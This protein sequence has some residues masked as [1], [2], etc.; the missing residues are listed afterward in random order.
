MAD[1]LPNLNSV[2][3]GG[4]K[5][6]FT[7]APTN[8][9]NAG[10]S[11]N[12]L[13]GNDQKGTYHQI[14]DQWF[15]IE[16]GLYN[17][18]EGTKPLY[19]PFSFVDS[20]TIRETL[21]NWSVSGEI[22]FKTDF[23]SFSR[24]AVNSTK[25]SDAP[26]IDRT[27]GRNR[28]HITIYPVDVNTTPNFGADVTINAN[29]NQ[30]FPKKYWEMSMDFIIVDIIDIDTGN[31]QGKKRM[32]VFVDEHHQILKEKNL[33]WSTGL[34]AAKK[35]GA[36]GTNLSDSQAAINP[37][38]VLKDFLTHVSTNGDTMPPIKIGFDSN[39]SIDNPNIPFDKI[40]NWDT[41][42]QNN[43]LLH[44]SLANSNGKSDLYYILSHCHSS[45]GFPVIFDYG[46]SSEDK[47]WHLNCLSTYFKNSKTEQVE[48]LIIEDGLESYVLGP[49]GAQTALPY[50][51][52]ADGT[53]GSQSNNFTSLVASRINSYKFSPMSSIDD[54]RIV[55]APYVFHNEHTGEFVLNKA[56]NTAKKVL[57]KLE[58]L[59]KMGLYNFTTNQNGQILLNL[60]KTKTSGQ[61]TK[62]CQSL[63]G[64]YSCKYA[65]LNRMILD[66]IFLNQSVAFQSPGL[67]LRTPGKFIHIDRV[68]LSEKNPFDDRFFG[69]WIITSVNHCFTSSD[70]IT[71]VVAT[72]LDC[73]SAIF[74]KTENNF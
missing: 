42:D 25:P 31:A 65:P 6:V 59:G 13:N 72:K 68:G 73:F 57:E 24:G 4:Y 46:R 19:V 7:S 51:P 17:Q 56:D 34:F 54:N 55:N 15:Y 50:I 29:S 62:Y 43:K 20:L 71:D 35:M 26:Y 2:E 63:N 23:E 61:M 3:Q 74:P 18:I 12:T 11:S 66:A 10:S 58:A 67:T 48:H 60:N 44:Y 41:G 47:G 45:E 14:R 28:L 40:G 64:P 32:Y 69:Q 8:P 52:R 22:I 16:V 5:P 36:I 21:F 49:N 39:G 1:N 37:H 53:T 30:K 9:T 33:E 27:D 70:Y 38:D